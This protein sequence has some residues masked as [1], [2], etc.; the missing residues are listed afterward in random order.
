M[1]RN[2]LSE[3]S[4]LSRHRRAQDLDSAADQEPERLATGPALVMVTA[5]SLGLWWG[6]WWAVSFLAAHI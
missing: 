6:L 5:V 3:R 1:N 4:P 2:T